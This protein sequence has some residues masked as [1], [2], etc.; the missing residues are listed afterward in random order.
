MKQHFII[1]EQDRIFSIIFRCT[2]WGL[3]FITPSFYLLCTP[4]KTNRLLVPCTDMQFNRTRRKLIPTKIKHQQ[5]TQLVICSFLSSLVFRCTEKNRSNGCY[6]NWYWPIVYKLKWRVKYRR[7]IANQTCVL[8]IFPIFQIEKCYSNTSCFTV[9]C[10]DSWDNHQQKAFLPPLK[11][12]A[13]CKNK[14]GSLAI[15]SVNLMLIK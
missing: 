10:N 8:F 13:S 4:F 14:Q 1:Y 9:V 3:R 7:G 2:L 11:H 15:A 5:Y 6:F 12:I